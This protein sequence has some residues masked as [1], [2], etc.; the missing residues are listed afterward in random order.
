MDNSEDHLTVFPIKTLISDPVHPFAGEC[1]DPYDSVKETECIATCGNPAT[2]TDMV[3]KVLSLALIMVLHCR[4]FHY[5][6]LASHV[7]F[8]KT[9][10]GVILKII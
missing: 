8:S 3:T 2:T 5:K 6:L 1:K 7:I 4:C 10:C 9:T